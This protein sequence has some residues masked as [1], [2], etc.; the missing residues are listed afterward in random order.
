MTSPGASCRLASHDHGD[1]SRRSAAA[2]VGD[3][4]NDDVVDGRSG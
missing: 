4:D 1:R 2:P 3:V